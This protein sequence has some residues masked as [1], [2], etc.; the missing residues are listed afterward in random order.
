VVE[1]EHAQATAPQRPD[2]SEAVHEA[3]LHDHRGPRSHGAEL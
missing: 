1:R 2:R 3:D